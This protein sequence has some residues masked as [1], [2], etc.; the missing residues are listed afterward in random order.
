MN[1]LT[2][3][4]KMADKFCKEGNCGLCS[5]AINSALNMVAELSTSNQQTQL[6][7]IAQEIYDMMCNGAWDQEWDS[8][9]GKLC[10][11]L[12]QQAGAESI[13]C[14]CPALFYCNMG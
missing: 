3:I 14:N 1:E 8:V 4:L 10:R 5:G 9:K 2:K 13:G 6:A 12:K 11:A 7:I